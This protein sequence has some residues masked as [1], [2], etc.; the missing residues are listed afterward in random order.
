MRAVLYC[1]YSSDSQTDNSVEGQIRDCKEFAK[2]NN[3]IQLERRNKNNNPNSIRR[4][5]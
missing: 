5:R 1:R 3:N 4:N 2:D